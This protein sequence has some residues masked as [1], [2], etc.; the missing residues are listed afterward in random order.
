M[1]SEL[2][3]RPGNCA[4][5]RNWDRRGHEAGVAVLG[6]LSNLEGSSV[7]EIVVGRELHR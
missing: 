1:D 7:H 5:S 3:I 4:V 6:T 2:E